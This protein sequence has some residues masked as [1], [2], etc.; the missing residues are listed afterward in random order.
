MAAQVLTFPIAVYYFH[1]LPVLFLF[2]NLIAIP[3]VTIIIYGEILLVASAIFPPIAKLIGYAVSKIIWLLNYFIQWTSE[4]SLIRIKEISLEPSQLILC[5]VLIFFISIWLLNKQR[6]FVFPALATILLLLCNSIYIKANSLNQE[7]LIIYNNYKQPY[8]EYILAD[9]T[10]PLDSVAED[11]KDNVEK[12]ISEPARIHFH[13]SL[14]TNDKR[15]KLSNQQL[16]I[17]HLGGKRIVRVRKSYKL[18]LAHPIETDYLII[19]DKYIRNLNEMVQLFNPKEIVIDGNLP[20]WKLNTMKTELAALALPLHIV[21][22]HGA[23][24]ISL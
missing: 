10:M 12:Y 5:Y 7:K 13:T 15:M 6:S 17:I 3:L 11:L 1:Q 2:T 18:K 16:D 19:S 20:L 21:P 23:K 14:R 4:F 22:E 8:I 24:I 9:K